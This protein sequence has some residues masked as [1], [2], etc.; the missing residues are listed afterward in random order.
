MSVESLKYEG[1][2]L[3]LLLYLSLWNSFCWGVIIFQ[4]SS[5]CLFSSVF[6]VFTILMTRKH[7][8]KEAGKMKE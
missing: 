3:Y 5:V 8:A 4:F 7:Q 2:W 1:G 6:R